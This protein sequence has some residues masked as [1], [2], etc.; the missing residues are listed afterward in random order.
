MLDL[1][2]LEDERIWFSPRSKRGFEIVIGGTDRAP[3]SSRLQLAEWLIENV[4]QVRR[5]AE[6][7][8]N[9]T[10]DRDALGNSE[11]WLE[12]IEFGRTSSDAPTEFDVVFATDEGGDW[13]ECRLWVV[14]CTVTCEE[15]V[16]CVAPIGFRTQW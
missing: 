9:S 10:V 3:D 8:L 14:R 6:G 12:G 11:W 1:K 13:T 16:C 2:F 5:T 15:S 7:Y 4:S